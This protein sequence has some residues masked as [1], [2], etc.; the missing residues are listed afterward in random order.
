MSEMPQIW[1]DRGMPLCWAGCGSPVM[2]LG[3][4]CDRH[5]LISYRNN[6]KREGCYW[7]PEILARIQKI[8]Q[9]RAQDPEL[10]ILTTT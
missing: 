2:D 1:M 3:E 6:S 4:L 8:S 5:L 9:A 7:T 10:V